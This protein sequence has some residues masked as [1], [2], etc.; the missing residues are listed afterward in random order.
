MHK[1]PSG[2]ALETVGCALMLVGVLA[3]LGLF[4]YFLATN[5]KDLLIPLMALQGFVLLTYV[6]QLAAKVRKRS[7]SP[8][9]VVEWISDSAFVLLWAALL[10]ESV[11]QRE[12]WPQGAYDDALIGVS[13]LFLIGTIFYW[14]RGKRLL[15]SALTARAAAGRWPWSAGG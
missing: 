13:G 5:S 12:K 9:D 1:G 3:V 6:T 7:P 15:I 14:W 4:V 10:F 11:G 2:F 8:E